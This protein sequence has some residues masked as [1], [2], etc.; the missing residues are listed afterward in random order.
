M[1]DLI[2]Q[3][4]DAWADCYSFLNLAQAMT[5]HMASHLNKKQ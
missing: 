5:P 3:E 1:W 2:P 4:V